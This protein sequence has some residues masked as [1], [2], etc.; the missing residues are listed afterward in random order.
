M[1]NA[2]KNFKYH[3]TATILTKLKK[4]KK[5]KAS[6]AHLCRHFIGIML[7][8]I[9]VLLQLHLNWISKT[10]QSSETEGNICS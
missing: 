3:R 1:V 2:S 10:V 8:K 6:T 9:S 7:M 5:K 4:V